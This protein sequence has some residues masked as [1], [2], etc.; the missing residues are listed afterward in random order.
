MLIFE[1]PTQKT[2]RHRYDG[3][4]ELYTPRTFAAGE[5]RDKFFKVYRTPSAWSIYVGRR[6]YINA[7]KE[8]EWAPQWFSIHLCWQRGHRRLAVRLAP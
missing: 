6:A 7:L 2:P 3:G 1:I 8:I 4:G 5:P